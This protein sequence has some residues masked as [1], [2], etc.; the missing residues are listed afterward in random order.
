MPTER[1][2]P[3][4]GVLDIET[5]VPGKSTAPGVARLFKLSSNESPLGPSPEAIAAYREI[6][7][8]LEDYPD[9]ASTALRAA[10]GRA[11]ARAAATAR[12]NILGRM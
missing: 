10:I 5:Y 2:Q 1:P 3:R 7:A 6:A 8:H 11:A 4:P 12:R 9:G